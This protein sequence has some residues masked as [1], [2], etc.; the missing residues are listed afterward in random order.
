MRD[1][2]VRVAQGGRENCGGSLPA[3]PANE[4]KLFGSFPLGPRL[5]AVVFEQ[6]GN[7]GLA[8]GDADTARLG[9]IESI[10]CVPD[11]VELPHQGECCYPLV[12]HVGDTWKGASGGQ[13]SIREGPVPQRT[14]ASA[15]ALDEC[16]DDHRQTRAD[17]RDRSNPEQCAVLMD[18]CYYQERGE[19]KRDA[20]ES[21][22][23]EE[24]RGTNAPQQTPG[25]SGLPTAC[26]DLSHGL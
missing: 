15:A 17:D 18:V 16:Q 3:H 9:G 22:N 24:K 7:S 2:A 13:R 25:R 10:A 6:L 20:P 12:S 26:R 21:E 5:Q 4:P 23:D 1:I 11:Q 14:T 8:Q 19:V